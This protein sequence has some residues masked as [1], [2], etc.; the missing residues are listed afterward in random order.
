MTQNTGH[1]TQ[2]SGFKRRR[3]GDTGTRRRGDSETP[4]TRRHGDTGTRGRGNSPRRRV[5]P[6]PH[7]R[8]VFSVLCLASCILLFVLPARAQTY[9]DDT[10]AASEVRHESTLRRAEIIFTI[11]LPFTALHSYLAVRGVEI[12]RQ[13]KISP[14][15]RRSDWNT[16][17]GL[18]ILFSGF[19]AFWDWLHTR[20]EDVSETTIAP[21][22]QIEPYSGY[23]ILDTRYPVSRCTVG[24][25]FT[26]SRIQ[27]PELRFLSIGF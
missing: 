24:D 14:Q 11:S 8:V 18:T 1:K 15:L 17:G 21:R 6:S 22:G 27:H 7:R 10:Q 13:G 9:Q 16:I 5:A 25:G 4:G 3:R 2:D 12:S 19:V 26:P 20:G 23:H